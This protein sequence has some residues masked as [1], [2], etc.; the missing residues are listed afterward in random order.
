MHLTFWQPIP[1]PH[2][3]GLLE[4]L[5]TAPWVKSV[6]LRYESPLSD[7]RRAQGWDDVEFIGVDVAPIKP[8]EQPK[9]GPDQVNIFTGF[10]THP[11]LWSVFKRI[12]SGAPGLCLVYAEAP[13]LRGLAGLGR[14]LKYRLAAQR[15]KGR[16]HGVLA[17]GELGAAFYRKLLGASV[18]VIPFA[19]YDRSERDR[20][21]EAEPES[22]DRKPEG[23]VLNNEDGGRRADGGGRK[24]EDGV[25]N[26]VDGAP[27][28]EDGGRKPEDAGRD[29]E[30]SVLDLAPASD[31]PAPVVLPVNTNLVIQGLSLQAGSLSLP[32]SGSTSPGFD[33][34]VSG[35]LQSASISRASGLS[36]QVSS[37][38]PLGLSP[39][40]ST[41]PQVSS[42]P[43][44]APRHVAPMLGKIGAVHSNTRRLLFVGQ[45]IWRKGLDQLLEALASMPPSTPPWVL[46][47]IGTGTE[48]GVF[49]HM[50]EKLDLVDRVRF[51]GVVKGA[52]LDQFYL[53]ADLVIVPSRWDGWGMAVNE[54][55]FAGVPVAATDCC[56]AAS[57]IKD[58]PRCMVLPAKRTEEWPEYLCEWLE[59]G[60]AMKSDRARLQ[61][62]AEALTGEAGVA[63][64]RK[65]IEQARKRS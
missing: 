34:Q 23:V 25:S 9:T 39:Q 10:H 61:K 37:S 36:S 62:A 15:L 42:A 1:S 14:S 22:E 45:C 41:A 47:V 20:V 31:S 32:P 50:A 3:R 18:P 60:G 30:V 44:F 49:M 8:G 58:L 17:L 21:M 53:R 56:G 65:T 7:E 2:Q 28:T 16:V 6:R 33:P 19:Y 55:L 40:V 5:A 48:V 43:P 26:A 13:E 27:K 57:V 38:A 54:A 51:R 12:P 59:W 64:L 4:A 52:S 29:S 24:S 11:G 63:L 35:L 46:D